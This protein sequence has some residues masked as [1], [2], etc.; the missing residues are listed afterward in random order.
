MP[1]PDINVIPIDNADYET[2]IFRVVVCGI[3]KIQPTNKAIHYIAVA[4]EFLKG[5]RYRIPK[6]VI[7]NWFIYYG[8]NTIID[9]TNY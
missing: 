5:S 4:K 7:E 8:T 6:S 9:E 1:Y 3:E 2:A